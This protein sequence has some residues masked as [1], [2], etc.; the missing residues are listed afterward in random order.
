MAKKIT[1]IVD[2]DGEI[3]RDFQGFNGDDCLKEA[4]K[5]D[6]V[7]EDAGIIIENKKIRKKTQLEMEK[8][9]QVIKV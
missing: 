5:I 6:E 4:K 7:M 2:E 3:K 1:I 8:E 9:K